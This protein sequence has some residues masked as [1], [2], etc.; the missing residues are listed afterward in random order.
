MHLLDRI[1]DYR[2]DPFFPTAFPLAV[3]FVARDLIS[4]RLNASLFDPTNTAPRR[5]K[6]WERVLLALGF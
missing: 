3:L 1:N 6:L 2:R 4:E 5:L